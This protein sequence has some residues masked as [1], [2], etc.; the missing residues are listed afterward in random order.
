MKN[1]IMFAIA[2]LF[3]T[4]IDINAGDEP[5]SK[6]VWQGDTGE[7]ELMAAD[8]YD[9]M[10]I[11]VW[12]TQSDGSKYGTPFGTM[13]SSTKITIFNRP[14]L[15]KKDLD[16]LNGKNVSVIGKYRVEG[17]GEGSQYYCLELYIVIIE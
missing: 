2:L 13:S 3:V 5:K 7:F 4:I 12:H 11:T 14:N 9:P 16:L 1:I 8:S 17:E 6:T 15:S 10:S